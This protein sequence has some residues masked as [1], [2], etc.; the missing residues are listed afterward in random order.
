LNNF[1]NSPHLLAKKSRFIN[2]PTKKTK[3]PKNKY[4]LPSIQQESNKPESANEST[5]IIISINP[6]DKLNPIEEEIDK[7]I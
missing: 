5:P 4:L 2:Y 7:S 6:M 1:I 3:T